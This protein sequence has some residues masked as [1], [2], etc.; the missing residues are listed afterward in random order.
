MA[1]VLT[2]YPEN[3]R[4]VSGKNVGGKG[5][6][7]Q[8]ARNKKI[9]LDYRKKGIP[10]KQA[11]DDLG[12]HYKT[13]EY[14]RRTDPNFRQDM[15]R[16]KVIATNPGQGRSEGMPSFEEFCKKYLDTVLFTHH[17]QW[18]DLLEDREPRDLHPSQTYHKGEPEVIIVNTPPEHAKSTT[19]TINYVTYRI[20][21]DPNIRII[22]VSKT[23]DMAKRFLRAVKDR[24]AGTSD[25]YRNL[26]MDFAPEGGFDA[27]SAAWTANEIYVSGDT[28]DSGEASPTVRAVGIRG[29]IYG[30]RADLIVMDDCVDMGNAHDYDKQIDWI[31]NEIQSRL[32]VPSGKLLLVGTRLQPVD[33]YSEIQKPDYYADDDQ[34]PWTYLTQPAVLEFS[35]KPEEWV[36]LWPRTNRP[37]V[38]LVARKTAQQDEDGLYPMWNG[39]ALHKKRSKMS[40]R[41]WAMVYMQEQVVEDAI[42]PVSKVIGCIDGM[43]QSGPLVGGAPGHRAHGMEGTYVIGGFDPAMTGHSASIVMAVDRYNGTRWI[44]DAWTKSHCKPDDIFNKIKELTVRYRINEWRI[45]KN[46]MNLMVTQNRDIKQFLGSRGCLLKEHFTGKNKW[47]ADFGV[48][49]MSMLFDAHETNQNLIHLPSRSGGEGVKA[50]VEQLTTWFPETKGKTDLVMALWFAEIRARELVNEQ[51]QQ[52]SIANPYHSLRDKEKIMTVDLDYA[53]QAAMQGGGAMEWWS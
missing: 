12:L 38:S 15:D 44:L 34:A 50:L 14:W 19:I 4:N 10:V 18:I 46:A 30:S 22:I 43:R 3:N 52:F 1:K 16:L 27:N 2:Y 28:R 26:Q 32:A 45:E 49:S 41:N 6:P 20:C 24:L 9:V 31:Q 25:A 13:Y 40:P 23:Q 21:E 47:D 35:D 11:M 8:A 42:F 7:Q 5:S 36:T 33:L 29:Q 51:D 39:P 37:P 53:S 48:A 17:L